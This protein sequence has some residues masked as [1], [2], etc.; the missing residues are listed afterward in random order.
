MLLFNVEILC[1]APSDSSSKT[2]YTSVRTNTQSPHPIKRKDRCILLFV[3]Y[4]CEAEYK[5]GSQNVFAD[6]L[7]H[8]PVR[9]CSCYEVVVTHRKKIPC[10]MYTRFLI[11]GTAL[12]YLK[13]HIQRLG[14]LVVVTARF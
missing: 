14:Y 12:N 4:I 2:D 10:S 1:F 13:G 7:Y 8:H 3:K 9:A 11:R 5:P 6:A